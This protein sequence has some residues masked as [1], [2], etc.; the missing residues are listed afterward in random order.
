MSPRQQTP[1][2]DY[3]D[4]LLAARGLSVRAFARKVGMGATLISEL[5]R[6]SATTKRLESTARRIT[7]WSN[8][9]RLLEAERVRFIDLA[10]L[11]H[12]PPHVQALIEQQRQLIARLELQVRRRRK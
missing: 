11:A 3:L 1:F 5:K 9:L 7:T 12:S 4:A 8:A 2:G 10:W 6:P